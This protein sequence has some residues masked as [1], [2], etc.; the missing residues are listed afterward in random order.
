[1]KKVIILALGA[2]LAVP[3]LAQESDYNAVY[4]SSS[5]K[6]SFDVIDHIGYGYHFVKSDDFKPA[7]SDEFFLNMFKIGLYP[8]ENLGLELGL[9][10]QFNTFASKESA[11]VQREGII[12]AADFSVLEL[13][14]SFDRQRSDFSI[15]GLGFPVLVKGI[16]NKF[17][18]GA[19]AVAS[20]N[21]T[22]D[23]GYNLRKGNRTI[24]IDESKAKV[25][26]FSYGILATMSYDHIGVYFKYYPKSS[27]ILP[28]GS[29][30]LNYMTLGIVLGL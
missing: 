21:I 4:T 23:T 24:N 18:I 13:G 11:F 20:W 8:V 28:D 29:V 2:I 27:H 26:P 17:Q 25:N 12:H 10:L 22:G 14:S 7:W 16:F 6:V 3:G 15:F 9:D 30:N 5:G 1:M 19:G